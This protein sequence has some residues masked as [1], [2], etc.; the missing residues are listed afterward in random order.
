MKFSR[1]T[2]SDEPEINLIAFIDILLVV[3]IF[4]MV[5]TTYSRFTELKVNLP[6]A[7]ADKLQERPREIIVT[8]ASDGRYALD[9][10][11]LEGRDVESLAAAMRVAAGGKADAMII[12]SADAM[13][14]HQSVINV[15]DAAR[16]AGLTRITFAAQ[17]AGTGR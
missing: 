1:Q 6:T 8:V 16:R 5:T 10:Q 11:V 17:N 13:A 3:L 15:L 2:E 12:V 9:R 14:V 7:D 4:L